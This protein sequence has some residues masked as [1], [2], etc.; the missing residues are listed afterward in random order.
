MKKTD[1]AAFSV[2]EQVRGHDEEWTVLEYFP[3]LEEAQAFALVHYDTQIG[4][5]DG[6]CK[7]ADCE[8]GWYVSPEW[9]KSLEV[10]VWNSDLEEVTEDNGCY[11][12]A[13]LVLESRRL[14]F[15]EAQGHAVCGACET[16]ICSK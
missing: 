16:L 14:S 11:S 3:T 1:S 8:N 2:V 4:Q 10:Q 12:C 6:D 5:G 9:W 7:C 13:V 15:D